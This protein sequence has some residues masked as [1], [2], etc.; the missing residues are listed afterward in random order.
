SFGQGI[1]TWIHGSNAPGSAGFHGTL[2]VPGAANEPPC[3]YEAAEWTDKQ[4]NIWLYGG[5]NSNYQSYNDLWKY[6]PAANV[7]TW[8]TGTNA[9]ND[10]GNYGI[11]GVPSATN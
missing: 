8:V 3:M 10:A 5:L 1:W 2:G 7:W 6:D 4:G 9:L 11:Q